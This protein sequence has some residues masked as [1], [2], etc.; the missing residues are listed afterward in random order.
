MN[1]YHCVHEAGKAK[2][3]PA[4][5]DLAETF[6]VWLAVRHLADRIDPATTRLVEDSIPPGSTTS[7]SKASTWARPCRRTTP[8]PARIACAG[9]RRYCVTCRPRP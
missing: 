9:R 8:P 6:S 1:M 2:D 4:T 3:N 5:E 7:T